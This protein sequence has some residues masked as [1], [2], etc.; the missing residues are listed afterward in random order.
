MRRLLL[1][2]LLTLTACS[3]FANCVNSTLYRAQPDLDDS[4]RALVGTKTFEGAEG[5]GT[6]TPAGRGGEI[7]IVD[8]LNA[9]GPGSLRAALTS[10]NRTVL[11]AV[12]GT[13]R[14]TSDIR[15]SSPFITVAGESAPSPGITIVGA[16]IY[17]ES[18]DIYLSH[19]A[20][21]PGDF[22][23]GPDPD[24]R[25]AITIAR[26][27]WL[28]EN[29]DVGNIV[30]DHCSLTWGIDETASTTY[31]KVHD[32]T[33]SNNII[34]EGLSNSLHSEGEHSKGLIVG[35]GS[36]RVSVIRNL[37]AHNNDRS[38]LLSTDA[39]AV[40]VNNLIYN[41]GKFGSVHYGLPG[42]CASH[43]SVM[44]NAVIAGPDTPSDRGFV[45][46]STT[47]VFH[48]TQ[49]H[50]E[51]NCG[52]VEVDTDLLRVDEPTVSVAPLTILECEN[53]EGGAFLEEVGAR[54]W[55]R[56]PTD[57][58]IVDDVINRR[59]SII[60]TPPDMQRLLDQEETRHELALPSDFSEVDAEGVTRLERFLAFRRQGMSID[61]AL[62]EVTSRN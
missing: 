53:I 16:G 23:E 42:C 34:S 43:L 50:D 60:D 2:S 46:H 51:G 20:I 35:K 26:D 30:I 10:G 17:I 32:V 61:A 1:I 31:E 4:H 22:E 56:D 47:D 8:N 14:I 11:F 58:R 55:N 24:V 44:G 41:P 52:R 40:S 49:L 5:F 48:E 38:P 57:L 25:D 39:S 27:P 19:L 15:I 62:V 29:V 12:G 36:R 6:D 18:H 33:F 59:G 45:F 3:D 21:R 9:D 13:I 7:V 37:F 28:E 54:P